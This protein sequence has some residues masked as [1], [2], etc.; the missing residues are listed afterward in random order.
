MKKPMKKGSVGKTEAGEL[1]LVNEQGQAFKTDEVVV[2]LW[3]RCD[4]KAT[5]DEL[6]KEFSQK[7]KQEES[8]VKQVVENL[9]GNMEKAGLMELKE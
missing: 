8:R 1:V 5:T 9:V 2:L 3:N 4:G 7:T 6:V